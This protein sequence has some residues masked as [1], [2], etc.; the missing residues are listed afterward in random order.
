MDAYHCKRN[1]RFE[2][3]S[4]LRVQKIRVT[5]EKR[6]LKFEKSTKRRRRFLIS[7][8]IVHHFTPLL[9]KRKRKKVIKRRDH[10]QYPFDT[11]P[12]GLF[13]ESRCCFLSW[14]VDSACVI[15]VDGNKIRRGGGSFT[16]PGSYDA[17]SHIPH[18][19][20]SQYPR[21]HSSTTA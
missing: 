21:P 1:E 5:L 16:S 6:W 11:E 19:R 8:C 4:V 15:V 2:S 9:Q 17:S 7:N 10:T 18:P 20:I 14:F 3:R 12:V 13:S